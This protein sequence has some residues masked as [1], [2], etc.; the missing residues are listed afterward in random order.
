MKELEFK[1]I[2][3]ELNNISEDCPDITDEMAFDIA[4]STLAFNTGLKEYIQ[5]NLRVH[6]VAGWLM[7]EVQ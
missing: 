3:N 5:N 1:K 7:Q 4:K 2:I 6:D